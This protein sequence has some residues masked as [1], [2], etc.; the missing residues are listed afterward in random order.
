MAGTLV[1][2]D[3][4][5]RRVD[6]MELNFMDCLTLGMWYSAP[7]FPLTAFAFEATDGTDWDGMGFMG[8]PNELAHWEFL[9]NCHFEWPKCIANIK[10]FHSSRS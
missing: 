7:R 3:F 9:R 4:P 8:Q 2:S 1:G 10:I 5:H 6:P